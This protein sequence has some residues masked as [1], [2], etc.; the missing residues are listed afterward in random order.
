MSCAASGDGQIC[1]VSS[2]GKNPLGITKNKNAVSARM[3]NETVERRQPVSQHEL[4]MCARR[5][6]GLCQKTAR[7]SCRAVRALPVAC[8]RTNRLHIIGVSVSE[9]KP[10]TST[11]LT[12]VTANSCKQPAQQSAHEQDGNEHRRQRERHGNDG[13]ADFPRA[14]AA[15]PAS[16]ARRFPCGA[17][18]F[19][20]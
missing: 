7:K 4:A 14:V 10:D 13:E 19:R 1:P 18:C 6:R 11:A 9:T 3:T 15:P 12:M 8:G 20:A 2:S 17:R 16:A 5:C